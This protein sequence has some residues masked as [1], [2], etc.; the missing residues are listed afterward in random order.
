MSHKIGKI[1]IERGNLV[2]TGEVVDPPVVITN[3][4][5]AA[6][7]DDI[8]SV[9]NWDEYNY[10]TSLSIVREGIKLIYD[11]V[12]WSGLTSEEQNIASKYF[13][14]SVSE[15]NS[16]MSVDEQKEY[17]NII[18]GRNNEENMAKP[19]GSALYDKEPGDVDST[20]SNSNVNFP[21]YEE[22]YYNFNP[23][24]FNT[25]HSVT[26]PVEPNS[27]VLVSMDSTSNRRVGGVRQVGS[28]N[29]RTREI[30]ANS[31]FSMP[32]KVDGSS[33]I[34]IYA[35]N[36]SITFYLTARLG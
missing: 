14:A 32:V 28:S 8:T 36:Q 20:L 30:S 2:R 31:M 18:F 12:G 21:N 5:N 3:S 16:I 19:L 9:V 23:S 33:N 17:G 26:L 4:L 25:W 1:K 10:L 11:S 7:Y 29:D 34:E 35:N 22:Y 27:I 6:I 13:V 24:I 15:R